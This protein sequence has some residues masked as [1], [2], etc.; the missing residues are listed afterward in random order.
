MNNE[1]KKTETVWSLPEHKAEGSHLAGNVVGTLETDVVVVGGGL[2]G[3]LSAYLLNAAGKKVIVLEKNKIGAGAT[4]FTTAFLTQVID[5]YYSNL[6]SMF[7]QKNTEHI[8]ES[9]KKAI[10]CIERIIQDEKIDCEF[11]RCSNFIYANT[12]KETESLQKE[13]ESLNHV[14]ISSNFSRDVQKLGF[15]NAG[16]IEVKNQ[17]K[18]HPLKF[19]TALNDILKSRG[20]LIFENSEV[21]ELESKNENHEKNDP[22]EKMSVY[23][24]TKSGQ[25]SAHYALVTTYEPFNKPLS[26]YFKKAFYDSYVMVFD[27]EKGRLP[28]GTYEDTENPYHYMRVDSSDDCASTPDALAKNLKTD[29][30]II[31]GE[32]HRS[33]VP[34]NPSKNFTALESYVDTILAEV[35]HTLVSKWVGPILEPV[36]G[37]PYIGPLKKENIFYA[38]AFSGNGMTYSAIAAS[39]FVDMISGMKNPYEKIY[40]ARRIP[41]LA[42]LMVKGRDFGQEFFGGAV[43]N[44]FKPKK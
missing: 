9:H 42:A 17:A 13:V 28:H 3:L 21:L 32:D 11:V 12:D 7:G 35:P 27:I 34:V 2:A 10:E 40:A 43:K 14:S 25:V 29:R 37:L 22:V 18:F 33:D 26:L 31:G 24:K 1:N 38:M 16:F 15:P 19:L 39:M 8:A 23:A 6:F 41:K 20:V 4:L 44:T 30:L 5:T 36:D